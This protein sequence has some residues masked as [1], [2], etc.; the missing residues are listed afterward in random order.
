[1][2]ISNKDG[3]KKAK[4]LIMKVVYSVTYSVDSSARCKIRG[5]ITK[6]FEIKKAAN[7]RLAAIVALAGQFSNQF[8]GD[9]RRL[10]LLAI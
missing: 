3:S 10:A 4:E 9:L 1:M 5:D 6:I 8:V 2:K 7:Q